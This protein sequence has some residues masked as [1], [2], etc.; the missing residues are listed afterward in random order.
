[1]QPFPRNGAWKPGHLICAA[2]AGRHEYTAVPVSLVTNVQQL[3][4]V[5]V[6]TAWLLVLMSKD[7]QPPKV[8]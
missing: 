3:C 2:G 4:A 8:K 7:Y 1:M 5:H 6:S